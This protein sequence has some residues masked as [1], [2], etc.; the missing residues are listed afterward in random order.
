MIQPI[1]PCLWFDREAK[2]AADFYCSLF[3]NS[4]I[5]AETPMVVT[6]DLNGQK[7]M[8][9]N[10]GP[11]HKINPSISIFVVCDTKEEVDGIWQQLIDGG[12]VL[13][14]LDR[15]DWSERYGWVSDKYGVNWQLSYGKLEDV[16]QKFTPTLMFVG[17]Q[18]GRAR[19]AM[20]FYTS[21]FD[22][23]EIIG[24]L[25]YA[26]ADPDVTGTVKHAQFK[27]NG[28]VFMAMD[29]S[30]PHEFQFN[31]GLSLVV[32]C[33]TQEE[34]DHY[35]AKLSKGGQEDRCGW[36]R[37]RFGV[38]W[39]IIPSILPKLMADPEKSPRVVDAFMKMKKFNI[40][41]LIEA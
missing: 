2:A 11:A 20:D 24:I 36:L 13:M 16:G 3:K 38:S 26:D 1:Y 37:D 12:S 9:L 27:L 25:P 14:P 30:A 17:K 41:Q 15:Y 32:E 31:E 19:E 34:I 8:G 39:Q 33:G 5:T 29:S 7:F 4:K 18:H 6:F 28:N 40:Q 10:G 23:S 21:I 22:R 35:W